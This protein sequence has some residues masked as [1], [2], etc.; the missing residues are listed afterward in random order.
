MVFAISSS[1]IQLVNN[2]NLDF[3]QYMRIKV[4]IDVCK[5]L[6]RGGLTSFTKELPTTSATARGGDIFAFTARR[7]IEGEQQSIL[8]VGKEN[9][10]VSGLAEV[11]MYNKNTFSNK[12]KEQ[13][14]GEGD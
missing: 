5:Y 2:H 13:M 6:K 7:P 9:V 10:G 3:A 4:S 14:G 11:G 12:N 1:I 8:S